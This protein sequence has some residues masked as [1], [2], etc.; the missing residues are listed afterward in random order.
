[1]YV[2]MNY[3]FSNLSCLIFCAYQTFIFK[4]TLDRILNHNTYLMILDIGSI[5]IKNI[6]ALF[7][8]FSKDI[9]HIE[10]RNSCLVSSSKKCMCI[11]ILLYIKRIK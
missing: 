2:Y 3:Y 6:L 8:W 10:T 11:H 7:N 5:N 4:L 1:M 9:L